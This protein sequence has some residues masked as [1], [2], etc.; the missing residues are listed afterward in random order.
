[1]SKNKSNVKFTSYKDFD[2]V[3]SI[4]TWSYSLAK[5]WVKD[6]LIPKG[7][8]SNIKMQQYINDGN[9]IPKHFPKKPNEYYRRRGAWVSWEDFFDRVD[10]YYS[11]KYDLLYLD[12]EDAKKYV[13]RHKITSSTNLLTWKDRPNNIPEQPHK[14]YK[15]WVSWKDFFGEHHGA[16]NNRLGM[17]SKLKESDVRII[18]HQLKL[19]VPS[20]ALAKMFNVSEMQIFRIKSGENWGHVKV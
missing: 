8:L 7:I 3:D 9:Y 5:E 19:G 18:K 20:N 17:N 10:K 12:F 2:D 11:V 6:N 4:V 13:Q 14:I 16:V 1:M 15:E